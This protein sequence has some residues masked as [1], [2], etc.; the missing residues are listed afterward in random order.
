MDEKNE[1]N[2]IILNKTSNSNST[3]KVL[4][5]IATFAIILII[6]VIVMN[7]FSGNNDSNLP[8]APQKSQAVVEEEVID[9]PAYD[10]KKAHVPVIEN[11]IEHTS[12]LVE[13]D[14]TAERAPDGK[15]ETTR[16][17]ESVFEEDDDLNK[18][19]YSTTKEET[20]QQIL[21][22]KKVTQT[23]KQHTVK[24]SKSSL[25]KH[26]TV[27]KK[28]STPVTSGAYYV[29]VGSFE[30]YKP[31]KVFL[32]KIAD[33]GYTYTFHKVTRNSKTVTK[34]LVGPFKTKASAREALPVIKTHVVSGA[35]LIKI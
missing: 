22:P 16:I 6:V 12:E 1:L 18:P 33:R 17:A 10:N 13:D 3:K 15:D 35:F 34:V 2:D 30:K 28:K 14:E 9:E 32:D 20:K 21:K 8:H 27:S 4:L 26:T 31:A 23:K 19:T 11:S 29:Q 7:Q 5:T 24:K 25:K